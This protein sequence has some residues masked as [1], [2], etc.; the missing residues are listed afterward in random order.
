MN[1]THLQIK[2]LF[3]WPE[4]LHKVRAVVSDCC[5]DLL[6]K[7]IRWV[8]LLN[9]SSHN[10]VCV[11]SFDSFAGKGCFCTMEVAW[12]NPVGSHAYIAFVVTSPDVSGRWHILNAFKRF[13]QL[14]FHP[15]ITFIKVRCKSF[16]VR[17]RLVSPCYRYFAKYLTKR[18]QF[19]GWKR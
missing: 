15:G 4:S 10:V 1:V 6:W 9:F 7:S 19:D 18:L 14:T 13:F 12:V 11:S 16:P 2:L 8:N 5:G 17:I 3:N